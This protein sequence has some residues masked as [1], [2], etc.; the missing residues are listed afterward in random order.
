MEVPV[1]L[2]ELIEYVTIFYNLMQKKTEIKALLEFMAPRAPK[3][4]LEIGT[5]GGGTLYL[6]TTVFKP[7]LL[8]SVDLPGGPFGGGYAEQRIALYE[9]LGNVKLIRDDSHKPET[10]LKVKELL[11]GKQLDMLFIDGDHTYEGV[12][13]DFR[14]YQEFVKKEG[15]IVFHDIH[16]QAGTECQVKSFWKELRGNHDSM[17]IIIDPEQLGAGI[18]LIFKH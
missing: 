9:S 12:K 1:P 16:D 13:E 8:I 4:I 7:D 14:M 2:D 15:V 5:C 18:G 6:F 17:E 10:Y 3:T 11:A